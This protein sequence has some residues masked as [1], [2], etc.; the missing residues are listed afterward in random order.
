MAT[1][2]LIIIQIEVMMET[3]TLLAHHKGLPTQFVAYNGTDRD[4]KLKI[5]RWMGA[6][7]L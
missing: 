3:P 5:S 7:S 6:I 2:T 4:G 1:M